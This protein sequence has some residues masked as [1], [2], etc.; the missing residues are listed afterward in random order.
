MLSLL[1]CFLSFISSD[2]LNDALA[3]VKNDFTLVNYEHEASCAVWM[4]PTVYLLF[5]N[6]TAQRVF[7]AHIPWRTHE[8]MTAEVTEVPAKCR[9][10]FPSAPAHVIWTME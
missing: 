7:R 1:V 2:L 10:D 5:N 4:E 3:S 6:K 8:F 9:P